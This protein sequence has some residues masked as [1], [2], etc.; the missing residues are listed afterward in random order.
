MLKP[1][2]I[3]NILPQGLSRQREAFE[4]E[5]FIF[6]VFLRGSNVR[7]M[8]QFKDVGDYSWPYF[9]CFSLGAHNFNAT[10]MQTRH[11]AISDPQTIKRL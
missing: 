6:E 9:L 5:L 2:I 11:T 7:F 3:L 1:N 8:V 10:R 4:A